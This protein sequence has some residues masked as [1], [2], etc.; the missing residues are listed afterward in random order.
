[1]TFPKAKDAGLSA[2]EGIAGVDALPCRVRVTVGF[3]ASLLAMVSEPES[4]PRAVGAYV[5][6]RVV[7]PPAAT[8]NGADGDQVYSVDVPA[9]RVIPVTLR[10]AVPVFC[11]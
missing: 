5:T 8:E 11:T 2:I 9:V 4:V 7:A 10:T 6:V 3:A 1:M